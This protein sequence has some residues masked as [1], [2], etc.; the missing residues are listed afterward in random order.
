MP[1]KNSPWQA[2]SSQKALTEAAEDLL[3]PGFFAT[4]ILRVNSNIAEDLD[5]S[6]QKIHPVKLYHI[7]LSG[8]DRSWPN[9][10]GRIHSEIGLF[11]H[12]L[13]I[14]ELWS[15][16]RNCMSASLVQ[17]SKRRLGI[18]KCHHEEA[19]QM[20]S[21][22]SFDLTGRPFHASEIH[23]SRLEVR[24][25]PTHSLVSQTIT[26]FFSNTVLSGRY[27]TKHARRVI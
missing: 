18:M 15:W 24:S 2:E 5:P 6:G 19:L 14:A 11:L 13:W 17:T 22:T 8:T 25:A 7:F 23:Q 3:T 4:H 16:S 20:G 1:D 26:I 21:D 12:S 27:P 10:N 9:I